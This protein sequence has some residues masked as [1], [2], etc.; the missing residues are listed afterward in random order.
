MAKNNNLKDYLVDLYEGISSRK[1]N[2]SKNPQDFRNEIE[3]L[4]FTSDAN[5]VAGDIRIGKTAYVNDIKLTGTIKD[6]DESI[7]EDGIVI[8]NAIQ[9]VHPTLASIEVKED[10]LGSIKTITLSE[11]A[12]SSSAEYDYRYTYNI[13]MKDGYTSINSIIRMY[14]DVSEEAVGSQF[15]IEY[16]DIVN[17]PV[18]NISYLD[19]EFLINSEPAISDCAVYKTVSGSVIQIYT[20]GI[21]TGRNYYLFTQLTSGRHFIDLKINMNT[22]TVGSFSINL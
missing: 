4:V 10:E 5:A 17:K 16:G 7:I 1:P 19:Q 20:D 14:F 12:T 8:Y 3:N 15:K 2:A 22:T 13:A 21:A 11:K 6:Y 9:S 18:F